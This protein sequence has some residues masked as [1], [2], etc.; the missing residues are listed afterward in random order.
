MYEIAVCQPITAADS[1]KPFWPTGLSLTALIWHKHKEE[2]RNPFESRTNGCSAILVWFLCPKRVRLW[3]GRAEGKTAVVPAQALA[4][5]R[6]AGWDVP[7]WLPHPSH[8]NVTSQWDPRPSLCHGLRHCPTH[9]VNIYYS[10]INN[11][12]KPLNS[13]FCQRGGH[14]QLILAG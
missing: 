11:S 12:R 4:S 14:V 6:V 8:G 9:T 2:S 13:V 3:A 1:L 5:H 10:V 7:P